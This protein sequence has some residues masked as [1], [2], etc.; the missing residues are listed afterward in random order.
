MIA[1]YFRILT[2][3]LFLTRYVLAGSMS[4]LVTWN[5]NACHEVR[6]G[7]LSKPPEITYQDE[8]STGYCI[9]RSGTL[10]NASFI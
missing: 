4:Y 2:T 3:L 6:L 7:R 10:A 8:V 5:P 9:P 1:R